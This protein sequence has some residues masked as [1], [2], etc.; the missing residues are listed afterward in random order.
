MESAAQESEL[1]FSN[2]LVSD[3]GEINGSLRLFRVVFLRAIW[4]S[5]NS[6]F[7]EA[8]GISCGNSSRGDLGA[9]FIPASNSSSNRHG[10]LQK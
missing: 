7:V 5:E 6:E 3:T 1:V 10:V 2:P 9:G 8:M 4:C